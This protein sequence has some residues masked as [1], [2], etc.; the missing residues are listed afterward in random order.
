MPSFN[1][2]QHTDET[3]DLKGVRLV[4]TVVVNDDPDQARRIKVSIPKLFEGDPNN[5]PWISPNING[6]FPNTNA[7]GSFHLVPPIGSK[8]V[9]VF[10]QGKPLYPLYEAFPFTKGQTP[11]EFLTN[12]LKRFGWKDPEGNLFF[13]DTTPNATPKM[14][15]QF[16]SGTT[17]QI[18]GDGTINI[19][20]ASNTIN[21][22]DSTVNVN[23]GD[24]IADGISLKHHVHGGVQSGPDTTGQPE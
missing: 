19:H 10:Q 1:G 16:V 21:I 4:G 18:D 3:S 15:A 24:V 14:L 17:I 9:V 20:A 2:I 6:W 8:V 11:A 13:V 7:Y 5:L 22:N 12:Y 23:N